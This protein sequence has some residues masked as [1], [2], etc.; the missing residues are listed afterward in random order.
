[1]TT[2]SFMGS[3]AV[4]IVSSILANGG[5]RRRETLPEGIPR[6]QPSED[7]N[8]RQ[9]ECD[10]EH[11]FQCDQRDALPRKRRLDPARCHLR[12]L[13]QTHEAW[14]MPGFRGGGATDTCGRFPADVQGERNDF[15]HARCPKRRR[16]PATDGLILEDPEKQV[17]GVRETQAFLTGEQRDWK[18]PPGALPK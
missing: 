14:C 18:V 12:N 1:M 10:H 3:S 11:D 2:R 7:G 17:S 13:P 6:K 16:T 4:S 8:P 9:Q 15:R 5:Q